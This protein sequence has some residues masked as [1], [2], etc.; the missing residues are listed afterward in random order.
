MLEA[1][2][3]EVFKQYYDGYKGIG[4]GN[5]FTGRHFI[6]LQNNMMI[7]NYLSDTEGTSADDWDW[8]PDVQ[9]DDNNDRELFCA[10]DNCV[11]N[12]EGWRDNLQYSLSEVKCEHPTISVQ[13]AAYLQI[14]PL[15]DTGLVG[16]IIPLK[17]ER[18]DDDNDKDEKSEGED[19]TP[20]N[21]AKICECPQGEPVGPSDC[22][23]HGLELCND[24]NPGW[25]LVGG[26]CEEEKVNEPCTCADG[27]AAKDDQC[28]GEERCVACDGY[29][30]LGDDHQCY[31]NECSCLNGSVDLSAPCED[32]GENVCGDCEKGYRHEGNDCVLNVCECD[33]GVASDLCLDHG[34]NHCVSCDEDRHMNDS[35]E[36]V[37]NVCHCAGGIVGECKVHDEEVCSACDPGFYPNDNDGCSANVCF[38]ENGVLSDVC[39]VHDSSACKAD[40]CDANHLFN[41]GKCEFDETSVAVRPNKCVCPNGTPVSGAACATN[42]AHKCSK[43]NNGFRAG[44]GICHKNTCKCGNGWVDKSKACPNHGGQ[45]CGGCNKPNFFKQG[46]VCKRV[47]A[48]LFTCTKRSFHKKF[49]GYTRV[50]NQISCMSY[51]LKGKLHCYKFPNKWAC[52]KKLKDIG[53]WK[54]PTLSCGWQH[55]QMWGTT[56]T[57]IKTHWCKHWW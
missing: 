39:D 57:S 50:N 14:A 16:E 43:C 17:V 46:N 33:G 51:W 37:K 26:R 15:V 45:M 20:T 34:T 41:N 9:L 27:T 13:R 40:S 48:T 5:T 36:C 4:A 25:R 3:W 29:R 47:P 32:H 52:Q 44:G 38:C 12:S 35:E 31:L 6:C 10:S 19:I 30:F 55:K 22:P 42:G 53:T 54:P 2:F 21:E 11:S 1:G 18:V 49:L 28:D 8:L 56:G 24:C 7:H 23:E